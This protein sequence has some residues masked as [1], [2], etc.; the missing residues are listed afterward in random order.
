[1]KKALWMIVCCLI[2]QLASAQAPKWAE[3]AKKAVF[4]VITYD[5]EN[6][7]KGTGN[8]FYIDLQGTALSDYSLFENAQRAVVINA[9]GKQLDV[10]RIMG[11]NSMYDIVKFQTPS[12]K[13]QVALTLAS[14]PAKVGETVYLLP[15]STQKATTLQSGKITAVDSIGSK[16]F[17]Y[18]LEM[19]TGEKMVSCPI[20]NANGEVLGM[21]QKNSS[22]DSMES[23]AIGA[24]Y[25]S[26]LEISALSMN[27]G[28]LNKIG[29]K[30][31]LPDTEEQALVFLYM[32]SEQMDKEEYF[33]ILNDFLLQY[34][35]SMEGYI[36]RASYYMADDNAANYPSADEDLKKAI[37]VASNK[38]DAIYQVSKSIYSYL[39]SL[40]GK[41]GYSAWTFD[42]ALELIQSAIQISAQPLHIQLEGD[43]L[44]AQGKYAEA[45]LSYDKV[46]QSPLVSAATFYSASKAKQLTEGSDINEVLAIMDKA[47]E[48]LK[49]PYYGEAAPYFYE[50]AE[51]RANAGKH[52]E[53]VMDYNT[54]FEAVH[55]DVTALFYFQREQA[56]MQCRMYQ[57]ALNDINKAVEMAPEDADFWV[58]KGSVHL[59]VNQLDEA[60]VAF[61]KALSLNDKY[62]AAYRMLGYCQAMQKK[63]KEACANFA[64][65]KELGDEVVDQLIEKYCK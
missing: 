26:S 64:K 63:N 7:I 47:I 6:K 27:D 35:N 61:N 56:E 24:S 43:I 3:K 39:I 22:D 36:R 62:A 34:P 15:Y 31:A 65:A 52:R 30:K 2:A 17:Y 51:L 9:D 25:G 53:A 11:A 57:Q 20:M 19:K 45:F 18:T 58:E 44:F 42:R 21:I 55:G 14:Q 1:M 50:R 48:M 16:S 33:S 46:N 37:E 41:E 13:K 4:S 40:N 28:A 49:K 32:S 38:E 60:I 54:F 8:G 5:K 12:E 29:I 23:Y 59:R 10:M